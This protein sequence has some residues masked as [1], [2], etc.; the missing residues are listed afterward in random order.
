MFFCSHLDEFLATP[1]KKRTVELRN[2]AYRASYDRLIHWWEEC[3]ARNYETPILSHYKE[4]R[5]INVPEVIERL[6]KERDSFDA[7]AF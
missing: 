5:A 1:I 4:A 3:L 7:Q 2:E 6:K